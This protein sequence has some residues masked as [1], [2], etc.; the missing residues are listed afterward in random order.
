MHAAK[1]RDCLQPPFPEEAR[2][3]FAQA[4]AVR[5]A[6]LN[7]CLL[8]ASQAKGVPTRPGKVPLEKGYSQL[9]W[10]RLSRSGDMSGAY[11][12]HRGCS[13]SKAKQT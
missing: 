10:M 3:H 7:T 1:E 8:N 9:D 4:T 12:S 6:V 13:L 11:A 5:V 2:S